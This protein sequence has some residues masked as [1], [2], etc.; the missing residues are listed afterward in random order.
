MFQKLQHSTHAIRSKICFRE[1]YCHCLFMTT[2]LRYFIPSPILLCMQGMGEPLNNYPQ[3]RA[4]VSMMIDPQVFALRRSAVT[5]STVG[6]IPRMLQMIEDLPG[7][8]LALSLHAPTQELRK[9]IVPS[10]KAH[11]LDRLMAAVDQY[12]MK[13]RQKVRSNQGL[14]TRL[15]ATYAMTGLWRG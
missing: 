1:S 3:V 4:A 7:V 2:T 12:Q 13:T 9:T 15:P 6:V 11:P 8:S 5:V 10:A 14:E